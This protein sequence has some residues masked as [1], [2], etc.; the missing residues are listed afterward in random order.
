MAHQHVVGHVDRHQRAVDGIDRV[1]AGENA[2]PADLQAIH[3][4]APTGSLAV[5]LH[6]SAVIWRRDALYQR[7]LWS[8]HGK[9]HA[10]DSV[11]PGGVDGKANVS[12]VY[13]HLELDALAVP[14]PMAL[15]GQDMLRP[16]QRFQVGQQLIGVG[17]DAKIPLLQVAPVHPFVATPADTTGVDLLVG[18]DG[19]AARTPPLLAHSAIGQATPVQQQE[20]PLRPAVKLRRAGVDLPLP[21]IG[22]A[23][24][25]HLATVVGRIA[26]RRLAGMDAFL[27]RLVLRRQAKGVPAHGMQHRIALHAMVARDDIGRHVIAPVPDAQTVTGGV[28]E[29]VQAIEGRRALGIGCA[30]DASCGPVSSPL[31]FDGLG[32]VFVYRFLHCCPPL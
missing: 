11:G 3:V 9:G 21:I 5:G 28:G 20:E 22:A 15:H 1:R 29:K 32:I 26:G 6:L 19:L 31:G 30:V 17:G 27:D 13:R 24:Q 10:I 2:F 18:Q 12:P 23:D 14:D 4:T 8:Q 16:V 7:V 25:G